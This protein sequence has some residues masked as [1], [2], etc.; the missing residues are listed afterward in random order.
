MKRRAELARERAR[1]KAQ[2]EDQERTSRAVAGVNHLDVPAELAFILNKL[3]DSQPVHNERQIVKV[4]GPVVE[5]KDMYELPPDI[6]Q[7]V[8]SKFTNIYFKVS[9]LR[10]KFLVPFAASY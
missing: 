9:I 2:K 8:F 6:D 5:K 3:E 10:T 4:V 7:H 1:I